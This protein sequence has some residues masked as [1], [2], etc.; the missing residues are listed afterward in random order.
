MFIRFGHEIEI[1]CAQ[2]TPIFTLMEAHPEHI[3]LLA[4][5]RDLIAADRFRDV[6]ENEISRHLAKPG[7]TRFFYDAVV[8]DSGQPDI[9]LTDQRLLGVMELP[10][11]VLPYLAPSRYCESDL[12]MA[13]AWARFGQYQSGADRCRAIFDAVH[14]HIHFGYEHANP[15][16]TALSVF[17]SGQGVC[18]DFAHLAITFCR[19][20]NIPARYCNGYL[21]DIGVPSN[22]AP[23]DFNAWVEVWL[24]GQWYTMDARHNVP[25]MGRILIARG[26]DAADIPMINSFGL[27]VLK[28]FKVWTEEQSEPH[29]SPR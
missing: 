27:H 9:S 17:H 29:L 22:P 15:T 24:D 25:R 6:F 5:R 18:R 11:A 26:R 10:P 3:G 2:P 21:G 23:M 14:N 19:A 16:G 20:M 8:E 28:S 13:D 1:D 12:L 7:P 4:E